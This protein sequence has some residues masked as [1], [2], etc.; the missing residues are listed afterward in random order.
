[1]AADSTNKFKV[2][3]TKDE[4]RAFEAKMEAASFR[5]D[6]NIRQNDVYFRNMDMESSISKH[7]IRLRHEI[8]ANGGENHHMT[9]TVLSESSSDWAA[10]SEITSVVD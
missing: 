4:A 1:M 7:A 5:H 8:D 9:F 6:I 10:F 3:L 2:I